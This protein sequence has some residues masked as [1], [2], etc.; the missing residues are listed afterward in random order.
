[1]RLG[2]LALF[3]AGCNQSYGIVLEDA[4]KATGTDPTGTQVTDPTATTSVSW[5]G[6]TLVINS[7]LSGDFLPWGE[8]AT[9][10]ATVT[11]GDGNPTDFDAIDWS[12]DIDGTWTLS[13]HEVVDA[14]LD[15]GTHTLTA[16]AELPNGDRLASSVG[17]VLVQSAYAGIYTGSI[18]ID[19]AY[20]T[21]VVS[22]IGSVTLTVDVYGEAAAGDANCLLDLFGYEVDTTYA[23]DLA[24]DDGALSGISQADLYVTTYDFET[25]GELSEDGELVGSFSDDV[26]GYLAVD[27]SIE[28]TRVTRDVNASE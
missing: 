11:D 2:L 24:N 20:D 6:A 16:T 28:A 17:G 3:A 27:G 18:N 8:D 7:P 19:L 23:I 5:E 22:C 15:V 14:G 13:G 10:S 26:Y 21:Y 1:M 9:F 12:S 4:T 25:E